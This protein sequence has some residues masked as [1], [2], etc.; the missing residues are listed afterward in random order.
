MWFGHRMNKYNRL[1]SRLLIFS[2]LK[3]DDDIDK[4][5]IFYINISN[6]KEFWVKKHARFFSINCTQSQIK[7]SRLKHLRA[8]PCRKSRVRLSVAIFF[9]S[10]HAYPEKKDFHYH[11]SR[12]SYIL[13]HPYGFS[14][15]R[16]N[17][18]MYDKLFEGLAYGSGV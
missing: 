12:G 3:I 16:N 11:P 1:R 2:I 13:T 14:R 7:Q 4:T 17:S 8:R 18:H 9:C 15:R 6:G 5:Y 10:P